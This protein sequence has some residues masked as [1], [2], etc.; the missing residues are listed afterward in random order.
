MIVNTYKYKIPHIY[1]NK[2]GKKTR[3]TKWRGRNKS[4]NNSRKFSRTKEFVFPALKA[5]NN[6]QET[7][8]LNLKRLTQ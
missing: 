6:G 5:L 1:P 3:K 8:S 4:L 7:L 2:G